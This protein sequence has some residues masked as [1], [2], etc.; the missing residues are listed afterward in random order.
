[1][2]MG[3]DQLLALLIETHQGQA[4]QRWLRRIKLQALAARQQLQLGGLIDAA[5]PVELG[6]RQFQRPLHHLYRLGSAL[7]PM[8]TTAQN[9]VCIQRRLPGLR[10]AGGVQPARRDAELV[11]VGSGLGLVQAV[12]Q[13]TALHR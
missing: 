5:A 4:Q 8:E 13:Q 12:E 10:Q 6:Q 1:M 7:G 2:V 9:R 3:V 11:D